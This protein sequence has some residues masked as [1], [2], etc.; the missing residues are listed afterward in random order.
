MLRLN[1]ILLL[2]TIVCALSVITSQ[3]N[4]R[5]RY[6]ALEQE[7]KLAHELEVEWGRLQLEQ[8]TWAMHSRIEIE[9]SHRLAMQLPP[10]NRVQMVLPL[11]QL[12]ASQ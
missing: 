2:V 11:N 8:S 9:A 6:T 10:P 12:D 1:M 7:Q 3:H 4:A 5:K